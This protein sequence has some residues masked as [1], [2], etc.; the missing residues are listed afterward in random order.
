MLKSALSITVVGLGLKDIRAV[1]ALMLV[2]AATLAG[3]MH[4][5]VHHGLGLGSTLRA[6]S[7]L[8]GIGVLAYVVGIVLF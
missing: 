2:S 5:A 7:V 6:L 3:A 8:D 1:W 4:L